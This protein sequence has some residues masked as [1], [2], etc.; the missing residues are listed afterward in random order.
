MTDD[1]ENLIRVLIVDDIAETRENIRKLLQFESD[2]VVVGAAR[3]GIEAIDVA[4]ET[5]P[6]VVI[7][8]INM[9]DMDG[10]EATEAMLRDVP[11][12]QIVML[13]VNNDSDYVRRAMRAGARDF[14]AKPP[15]GD[16]LITTIRSLSVL[17]HEQKEKSSTPLPQVSL[18]GPSG[19]GYTGPLH[20]QG[21]IIAVYSAKGGV[22]CTMLAVNL[23]IGLDTDDTPAVLVDASLQFGDIAVA[24]NLQPKNSFSDLATRADE[25]DP[26]YVEGVLLRHDSGL[27]VLAAPP[28]PE[29]ADEVTAN[30]VRK[31]LQFFKLHFAY[32]IVDTS[33]TMDDITLAVLDVADNLVC[34]A[35]PE[36][37]SIKDTRL[38]FD[39]LGVLEFPKER[40]SFVLNRTDRK[41][42]ITSEAVSEN[43]KFAVDA[44]IPLDERAVT[45]SINRGAPLLINDRS[46]PVAKGIISLLGALKERMVAEA[47]E[48]E[49][50]E[51]GEPS[52]L[53]SR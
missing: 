43:L 4:R 49:E 12:A 15:S 6:D 52:R 23:A 21:K 50:Q 13:S 32:V 40:I 39:L 9:P 28:R 20:P 51:E 25:L 44:E 42:G 2:V 34:V 37:P 8:D 27:R 29:M 30:E 17:A 19:S 53:F 10:I 11:Y 14:L 38:L 7:M 45:A 24:L 16:E 3:T 48:V 46:N 31:V 47:E 22:G 5:E 41:S 35:T 1:A 18:Q 36:I 33:S 26:E